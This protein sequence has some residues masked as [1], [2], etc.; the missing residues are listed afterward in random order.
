MLYSFQHLPNSNGTSESGNLQGKSNTDV[1]TQT[2]NKEFGSKESSDLV[3]KSNAVVKSQ[4][5]DKEFGGKESSDLEGKSNAVVKSQTKNS[6]SGNTESE[7]EKKSDS[8]MK[9]PTKT[10]PPDNKTQ[11]NRSELKTGSLAELTGTAKRNEAFLRAN[12]KCDSLP[13]YLKP[14]TIRAI[15]SPV[16]RTKCTWDKSGKYGMGWA[17]I[18]E[19]HEHGECRHQRYY[20]THTG[21]AIGASSV[22]LV[23]PEKGR[24]EHEEE[25][26][27]PKG[28]VVAIVVNMISV[29]LNST[30][31]KIAKIFEDVDLEQIES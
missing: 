2:T 19:K 24:N 11:S 25:L 18:P 23:L 17:V 12:N 1:K 9:S 30:A 10:N 6:E 14:E 21:G 16:E 5:R 26:C 27:P 31:L 20:A 29:G 4:T 15:W 22:L 8:N 7:F 28:V 3:S 13:G